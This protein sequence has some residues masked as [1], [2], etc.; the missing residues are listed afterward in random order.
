MEKNTYAISAF[1][2]TSPEQAFAY[3]RHL[4]NL[5]EW[6]LGSRMQE[7]V[8][9]DTWIGTAS[10]YQRT[11]YYHV[12]A[13]ENPRFHA[14][15]WQCGYTYNEYFKAYPVVVF[16]ADYVE[17][18]T[19]ERG[20]YFHWVAAIDPISRTPMI[21]EGI[22]TVHD[23]EA[24]ALKAALERQ[25]GLTEAARG[26]YRIEA[27]TIYIHAP[28]DMA[29]AFL[30]DLRTMAD[31]SHLLKPD[32]D[33]APEHGR[34][35]DEYRQKVEVT[36]RTT[37]LGEHYLVEQDY[38][39]PEHDF[40]QRSPTL[41][42]PVSHAFGNPAAE[43]VLLHRITFWPNDSTPRHGK[44]SLADFGAENMNIKRLLEKQ[45]G[46]MASFALGKSYLPPNI[47]PHV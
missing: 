23:S 21:M 31:W 10:G 11:L 39:Y 45:A 38:N 30:G 47:A 3:L 24:R 22:Q 1:I 36:L 29:V 20:V 32:G 28:L 42:I 43:G 13:L 41:L 25:E 27:D 40:L 44:L 37:K 35:L 8:D 2:A 33:I 46:N 26:K 16:P 9:D 19:V 5:D 18:D 15:E 34:F 14:I 6:T 12:R 4:P 17:P 7:Q